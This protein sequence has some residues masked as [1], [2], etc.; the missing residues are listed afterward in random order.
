MIVS[1]TS[2]GYLNNYGLLGNV[3]VLAVI[4]TV[5][6]MYNLYQFI[7]KKEENNLQPVSIAKEAA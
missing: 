6:L 4:L 7:S 5:F 2:T 3:V 1:E